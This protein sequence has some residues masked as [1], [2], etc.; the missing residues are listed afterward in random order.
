MSG[1]VKIEIQETAEELKALMAQQKDAVCHEKL[2]ALYWLKTKRQIA[3]CLLRC[4][5]VNIVPQSKDGC[6]VIVREESQ[7]CYIKNPDREDQEL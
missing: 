1:V 3:Y 6:L 7:N 4:A 2:Q 5:S